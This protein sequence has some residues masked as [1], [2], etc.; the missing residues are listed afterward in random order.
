MR[1]LLLLPAL[2]LLASGPLDLKIRE[3][4]VTWGSGVEPRGPLPPARFRVV[5]DLGG[6]PLP[7]KAEFRTWWASQAD[8]PRLHKASSALKVLGTKARLAATVQEWSAG[9]WT[10]RGIWPHNPVTEDRVVVEVW[11]AGR[12]VAWANA[13]VEGQALP[14]S[15]PQEDREAP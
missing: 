11:K 4:S 9:T 2:P 15:R 1:R 3:A 10:L 12:R 6:K 8:L 14:V 5:V 7:A 13:S